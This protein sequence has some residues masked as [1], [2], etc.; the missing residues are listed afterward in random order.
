M[1]LGVRITK[2]LLAS[3]KGAEVLYSLRYDIVKKLE[4]DTALLRCENVS[5]TVLSYELAMK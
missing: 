1:E 4:V 3:G 5:V 2:A